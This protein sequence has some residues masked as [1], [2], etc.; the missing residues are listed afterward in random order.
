ML[1]AA[2][3]LLQNSYNARGWDRV[4]PPKNSTFNYM[5]CSSRGLHIKPGTYTKCLDD[6]ALSN[7]TLEQ[8]THVPAERQ[9]SQLAVTTIFGSVLLTA[10]K[11]ITATFSWVCAAIKSFHFC[12]QIRPSPIS[13]SLSF[14]QK[15][16]LEWRMRF[17]P[18]NCAKWCTMAHTGLM[19]SNLDY[20]SHDLEMSELLDLIKFSNLHDKSHVPWCPKTKRKISHACGCRTSAGISL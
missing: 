15:K 16:I 7:K 14:L 2:R 13:L 3:L 6:L 8:L 20:A 5:F 10:V 11:N 17:L 1:W 19:T 18:W 4:F 12:D 9:G